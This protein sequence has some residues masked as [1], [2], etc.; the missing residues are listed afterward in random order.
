METDSYS[1]FGQLDY[2]LTSSLVGV[3][4]IRYIREEK[5]LSGDIGMYRNL[6]DR[7]LETH[8]RLADLERADLENNQDSVVRQGATGIHARR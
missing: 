8:T 6:D 5:S 4:G 3:A 7:V 1:I 2:S